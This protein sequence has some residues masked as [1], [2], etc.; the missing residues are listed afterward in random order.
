MA[1]LPGCPNVSLAQL[2]FSH[3]A[4]LLFRFDKKLEDRDRLHVA[5]R[6]RDPGFDDNQD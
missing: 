2:K 6:C 4:R 1:G 5:I 3:G